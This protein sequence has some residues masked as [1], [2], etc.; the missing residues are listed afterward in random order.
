MSELGEYSVNIIF[1][2]PF[3][4]HTH[5]TSICHIHIKYLVILYVHIY[6][7][8][9]FYLIKNP[10]LY[11]KYLHETLFIIVRSELF[12]VL[13]SNYDWL[14]YPFEMTFWDLQSHWL[15]F[16]LVTCKKSIPFDDFNT[17]SLDKVLVDMSVR[18]SA[19]FSHGFMSL[20][21]MAWFTIIKILSIF[22]HHVQQYKLKIL[23]YI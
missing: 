23:N 6:Q 10:L 11:L 18:L 14:S 20:C 13:K 15:G 19:D 3:Q 2:E 7:G 17:W 8:L 12:S 1:L 16:H 9:W 22:L 5:T 4:F 21:N